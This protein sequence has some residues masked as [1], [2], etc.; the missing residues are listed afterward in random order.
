MTQA[1]GTPFWEFVAKCTTVTSDSTLVPSA[2]DSDVASSI[3]FAGCVQF[4]VGD[5]YIVRVSRK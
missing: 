3:V 4:R 2:N 5:E 1:K